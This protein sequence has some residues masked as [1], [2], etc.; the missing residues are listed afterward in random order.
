MDKLNINSETFELLYTLEDITEYEQTEDYINMID[1]SVTGNETF[2]LA[3]GTVSHNSAK[4]SQMKALGNYEFGFFEASG[5][6]A[7]VLEIDD[8]K[9][10]EN[11]R[12]MPELYKIIK[13]ENYE[14]ILL[15]S[16]ADADGSHINGLWLGFLLKYFPEKLKENRVGFLKMPLI[17]VRD[18]NDNLIETL[19]NF[20]EIKEWE[21][22]ND[23]SKYEMDYKKGYGSL[24]GPQEMDEF[25][26]KDGIDRIIDIIEWEPGDEQIINNWL[27]S[28]TVQYRKDKIMMNK[29]DINKVV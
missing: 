8:K 6:P 9:F 13:A 28:E 16:D 10:K 18:K 26:S 15:G 5:V 22:K 11:K 25:V 14:Y 21:N 17:V 29:F 24:R 7:N 19:Y 2:L 23:S 27:S 4:N 3:N 12:G 20:D 1:L